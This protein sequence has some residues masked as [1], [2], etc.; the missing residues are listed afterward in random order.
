[1]IW[2]FKIHYISPYWGIVKPT[3]NKMTGSYSSV[4]TSS[5]PNGCQSALNRSARPVQTYSGVKKPRIG[6]PRYIHPTTQRLGLDSQISTMS[7]FQQRLG[8]LERKIGSMEQQFKEQIEALERK[9]TSI[10]QSLEKADEENRAFRAAFDEKLKPLDASL[11]NM[12][13]RQS[14]LAHNLANILQ[15]WYLDFIWC[16]MRCWHRYKPTKIKEYFW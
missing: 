1:M 3:S 7:Q 12:F 14:D 4:M 9:T 6:E 11:T 2:M 15:T 5:T 10:I 16:C 13:V 8:V